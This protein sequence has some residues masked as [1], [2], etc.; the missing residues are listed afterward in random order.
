[1]A[2]CTENAPLVGPLDQKSSSSGQLNE[3][4]ETYCSISSSSLVD[5][6]MTGWM[7]ESSGNSF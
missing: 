5:T 1:M 6:M 7:R 2:W 4:A 3:L